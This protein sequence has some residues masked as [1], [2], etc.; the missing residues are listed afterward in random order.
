MLQHDEPDDYV[1]ATGETSSLQDFVAEAFTCV[2]L[3]WQDFVETDESLY[4]PTDIAVG[5]ANPAKAKEKL[6]WQ[7]QYKLPD[8]VRMMIE[9]R[10]K[11]F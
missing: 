9:A 10:Q 4:R 1:I 6:G 7:A 2:G 5:R 8:V 3:N 11:G